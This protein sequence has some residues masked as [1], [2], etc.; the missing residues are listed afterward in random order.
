M[1]APT[2]A[3]LTSINIDSAA[4]IFTGKPAQN[5]GGSFDNDASENIFKDFLTYAEDK[6]AIIVKPKL[7]DVFES[8]EVFL[9][10]DF[11]I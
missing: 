8:G 4:G 10:G 5:L 2:C 3:V 9:K 1:D 11:E 6:R 7:M